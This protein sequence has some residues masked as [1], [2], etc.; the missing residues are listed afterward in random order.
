MAVTEKA[1][2]DRITCLSK[3]FSLAHAV[4]A[5]NQHQCKCHSSEDRKELLILAS[6]LRE[7]ALQI[8]SPSPPLVLSPTISEDRED[9]R[10][11]QQSIITILSDISEAEDVPNLDSAATLLTWLRLGKE[12]LKRL[13]KKLQH[14]PISEK[15]KEHCQQEQEQVA[16]EKRSEERWN[17][18]PT[19]LTQFFKQKAKPKANISISDEPILIDNDKPDAIADDTL[20]RDDPFGIDEEVDTGGGPAKK[21]HLALTIEDEEDEDAIHDTIAQAEEGLDI[22]DPAAEISPRSSSEDIPL[23]TTFPSPQI[24]LRATVH[25]S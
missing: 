5:S 24:H 6:S 8:P 21:M 7:N 14:Q 1:D 19:K 4:L 20:E 17:V 25:K 22:W 12:K 2:V 16:R 9:D 10:N 23:T 11:D 13:R 18:K 3:V 15:R